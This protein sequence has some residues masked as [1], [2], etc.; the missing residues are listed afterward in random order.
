MIQYVAVLPAYA[1][2]FPSTGSTT[3]ALP[4]FSPRMRG[5]FQAVLNKEIYAQVLPAY[6][7]MFLS[8]RSNSLSK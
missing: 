7:G 8:E 1:G 4:E 3:G 5:C 2:M 6:A